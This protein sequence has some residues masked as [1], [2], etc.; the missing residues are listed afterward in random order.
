VDEHTREALS[1][2]VARRID[3]DATVAVLDR[4]VAGA[5]P[6]RGSSAVTMAPS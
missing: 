4:L 5:R 3:A 2:T 6:R 1:I